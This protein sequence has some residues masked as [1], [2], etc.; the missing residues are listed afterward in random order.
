MYYKSTNGTPIDLAAGSRSSAVKQRL[1]SHGVRLPR[2]L[3]AEL[4]HLEGVSR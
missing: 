3:E 4:D 2:A 1:G